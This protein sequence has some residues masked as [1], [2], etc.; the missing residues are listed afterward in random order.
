MA[1]IQV[2]K[3]ENEVFKSQTVMLSGHGYINCQFSLCTLILTNTPTAL[4]GCAFESCNWRFE[5][6]VIW[7]DPNTLKQLRQ[8]LDAIAGG[9]TAELSTLQ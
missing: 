6:D 9:G 1:G 7:G 2:T 4:R 5:Y 3:H 8:I